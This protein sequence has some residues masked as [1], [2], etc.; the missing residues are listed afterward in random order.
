MCT[1]FLTYEM[2]LQ[3]PQVNTLKMISHSI[4]NNIKFNRE[5]SNEIITLI[6]EEHYDITIVSRLKAI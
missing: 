5:I 4:E 6:L 1:Q 3:H 2:M